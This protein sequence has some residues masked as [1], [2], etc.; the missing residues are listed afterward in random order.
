MSR[1]FKRRAAGWKPVVVDGFRFVS[2]GEADR[3][4]A[5]KAQRPQLVADASDTHALLVCT[6]PGLTETFRLAGK[7]A[8]NKHHAKRTNIDGHTFE[9]GDEARRWVYLRA[10]EAAGEIT[11]LRAHPSWEFVIDGQRVGKFTPDFQYTVAVGLNRGE[12]IVEDFKSPSTK[13]E[14]YQLRKKLLWACHRIAI[15]EVFAS[16]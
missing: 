10:L 3:Y 2:R 1:F 16:R 11:D 9:S 4:E 13:T 8:G 6:A 5:L 7:V 14:A 12:V 15:T